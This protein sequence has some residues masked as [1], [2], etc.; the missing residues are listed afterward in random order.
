METESSQED[1]LSGTQA[2]CFV[3]R[4]ASF[5]TIMAESRDDAQAKG[6]R[7]IMYG[8]VEFCHDGACAH[9]DASFIDYSNECSG[10]G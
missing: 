10:Q 8:P 9:E 7:N 5:K 3:T 4:L 2:F 1:L 6:N